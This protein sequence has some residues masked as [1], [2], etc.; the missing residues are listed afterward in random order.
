[1]DNFSVQM[2][3][4]VPFVEDMRGVDDASLQLVPRI[5]SFEELGVLCNAD[6]DRS[7]GWDAAPAGALVWR[8]V[9]FYLR[10]GAAAFIPRF[11]NQSGSPEANV[12]VVHAWP[13]APALP[14]EAVV[15]PD[16]SGR[17]GV[18]GLTNANG[19]VGFGYSGGMVYQSEQ[20]VG[21][22]WPLC[23]SH[24]PEPKYADCAMGLG[25]FGGTDHLTVNPVFQLVRKGGEP[26]PEPEPQPGGNFI[27]V[28]V[29]GLEVGIIPILR[30]IAPEEPS[31]LGIYVDGIFVGEV[32][33]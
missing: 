13:G 29:G 18:V 12:A 15:L 16:Y 24:L 32:V 11:N 30:R 6:V 26:E 10:T 8:C 19:D 5:A 4:D 22:I 21:V 20:G 17:T 28:V 25:W 7:K 31:S 33:F 23:P 3:G 9:G 27:R 2:I 1:M 14:R